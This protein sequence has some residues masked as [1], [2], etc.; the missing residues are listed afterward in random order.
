[1]STDTPFVLNSYT[2][3]GA[4]SRIASEANEDLFM[5]GTPSGQIKFQMSS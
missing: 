5:G 2:N 4:D 1:M 3:V